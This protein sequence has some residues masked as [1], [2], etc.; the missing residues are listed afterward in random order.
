M[1]NKNGKK[2][3]KKK[4]NSNSKKE[5]IKV[6]NISKESKE[7]SKGAFVP[8][9]EGK[10]LIEVKNKVETVDISATSIE[11]SLKDKETVIE[12]PIVSEKMVESES[13]TSITEDKTVDLAEV[14]K[15]VGNEEKKCP[16][17]GTK[18]IGKFCANC[19]ANV[20]LLLEEQSSNLVVEETSHEN[21]LEVPKV[22]NTNVTEQAFEN[23]SVVNPVTVPQPILPVADASVPSKEAIEP[24]PL[25]TTLTTPP[26]NPMGVPGIMPIPN[27]G[28]SH[29][30]MN[31]QTTNFISSSNAP[32]SN[33][34]LLLVISILIVLI[35]VFLVYFLIIQKEGKKESNKD[36]NVS[37][38]NSLLNSNSQEDLD[39]PNTTKLSC[40][41]KE[42]N[43]QDG[44]DSTSIIIYVFKDNVLIETINE[45]SLEFSSAALKY[46]G[47]YEG[48]L[49][50][51]LEEERDKF[52]NA[53]LE[54][55]KTDNTITSIYRVD[56]TADPSNPRNN[57][58]ELGYTYSQTKKELEKEGYV[59]K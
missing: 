44:I 16:N 46:F 50:E 40:T 25:D 10:S 34:K 58:D 9:V 31:Y 59:C 30:V 19:G 56:M 13:E 38:S 24:I 5:E 28:M 52:D 41:L 55:R 27:A 15:E 53:T 17:C 54:M 3:Q 39:N 11:S 8:M 21:S 12:E 18:I 6:T 35:V 48:A 33:K 2:G 7:N 57:L 22:E 36:S 4:N 14:P 1:A 23:I 47:Y 32:R 20:A 49:K 43:F 26:V 37:T 45:E 29:N 51:M 42:E